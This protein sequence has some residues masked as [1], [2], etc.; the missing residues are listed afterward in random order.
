MDQFEHLKEDPMGKKALL[1]RVVVS[2]AMGLSEI[3]AGGLPRSLFTW[4]RDPYLECHKEWH[5]TNK[6]TA[7]LY[8]TPIKHI[9]SRRKTEP[10][11]A[12][13]R[14]VTINNLIC[15][16]TAGQYRHRVGIFWEIDPQCSKVLESV[17]F[18]ELAFGNLENTDKSSNCGA[19]QCNV[20]SMFCV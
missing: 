12:C 15:W 18:C 8:A 2:T 7:L 1:L 6:A 5:V 16:Y 20:R 17:V 10:Q 9:I 4:L 11:I 14:I 19:K 3:V 13:P